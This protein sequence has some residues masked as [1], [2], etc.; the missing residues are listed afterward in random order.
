MNSD[1]AFFEKEFQ[2]L[3]EYTN[4]SFN[5]FFPSNKNMKLYDAFKYVIDGGGKR[6]RPILSMISA[7]AANSEFKIKTT[8]GPAL[9]IEILHNF[10]L[11]HDDIMDNSPVRHGIPTV[12][13]NWNTDIAILSGDLMIGY[14]YKALQFNNNFDTTI[15]T[16][17]TN[18]LSTALIEVC[19]GQEIDTNFNTA[20]SVTMKEYLKMIELKTSSLLR[21]AAKLGTIAT[22]A[23]GNIISIL[24]NYA[25]YL[26]LAFQ[27][28][29]DMLDFNTNNTKF[30][31][32]IGQDILER[33]KSYPIIR[34]KKLATDKND[35]NFINKYY[36][37]EINPTAKD[38]NKF[39]ELF[40]KLKIHYDAE[41]QVK[42]YIKKANQWHSMLP[43]NNY[44][45][46]LDWLL[47]YILNR[48]C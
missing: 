39:I 2:M 6:I 26:G 9:A 15:L 8:I 16:K 23:S 25:L 32:K 37:N 41:R 47:Y 27:I 22:G 45:Q 40:D 4:N 7:G 24:D 35:I 43:S 33:K 1:S 13:K 42:R 29:D 10:T 28:Q 31:K 36:F 12:H 21:C 11:I 34:A 48:D 46:M 5:D 14:A 19:E 44:T 18:T 30:G 38:V 17:L 20:E 3:L